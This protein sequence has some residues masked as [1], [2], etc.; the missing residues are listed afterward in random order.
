MNEQ[1]PQPPHSIIVKRIKALSFFINEFDIPKDVLFKVDFNQQFRIN[2]PSDLIFIDLKVWYSIPTDDNQ[3]RIVLDCVVQNV[4]EVTNLNIF[5]K[6]GHVILPNEILVSLVGLAITH[7]RAV[8]AINTSGTVFQ[9]TLIPVVNPIEATKAFFN[10]VP[11]TSPL[12]S[13]IKE[14]NPPLQK[15][16]DEIG[17]S[18][19]TE[20][21]K[22]YKIDQKT[23]KINKNE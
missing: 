12:E 7:T 11:D 9:D 23:G 4:F 21:E 19:I 15:D 18:P 14:N 2:A 1:E 5:K 8:V 22:K 16:V 20:S 3:N 13:G 10:S 6:D 17:L